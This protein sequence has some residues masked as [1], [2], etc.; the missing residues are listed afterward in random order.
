MG[1]GYRKTRR[2]LIFN[3]RGLI[4]CEGET[5]ENYFQGLVSQD[6]YRRKFS[7][8]DVKIFKPKDHSPLG[9]VKYAKLK[10]NEAKKEKNAYD[11]VWVIFDKDGHAKIPE[12]F[13]IARVSKP[14]IKIAFTIPCFEYF[15]LLHF[16]K[17]TKPFKKCD[18][19]ISQ[20]RK[21]WLPDYEKATNIFETLLP[22]K[23]IGIKNSEWIIE[24]F[25]DE[26]DS[27]KRI[28]EISAYSNIHD[29]VEYLYELI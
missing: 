22:N 23:D 17:T 6:K 10:I 12:A 4:L 13:E 1:R 9:L 11:F 7:S 14:E 2:K 19:V 18:A 15:V 29:L 5:E 16:E 8:V 3:K 24:Q 26:I 21:K 28:Y 20:I 25:N 27:G